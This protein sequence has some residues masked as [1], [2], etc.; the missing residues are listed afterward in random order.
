[1]ERDAANE[2]RKTRGGEKGRDEGG[3]GGGSE[4]VELGWSYIL[5]LFFQN[6]LHKDGGDCTTGTK[7]TGCSHHVAGGA[8]S[9]FAISGLN[10]AEVQLYSSVKR[11]PGE[12]GI[13]FYLSS[14]LHII[15]Q[16]ARSFH[17]TSESIVPPPA[18]SD[19]EAQGQWVKEGA[20]SYHSLT[21]DGPCPWAP[22]AISVAWGVYVRK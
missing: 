22:D 18:A 1:M 16:G 10:V 9:F 21:M 3:R 17:A 6:Y 15:Q 4:G 7:F 5:T 19:T 12:T 11:R 20:P 2:K 14:G 8:Q 13:A